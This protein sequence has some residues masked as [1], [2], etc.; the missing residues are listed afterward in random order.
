[1][2]G[3]QAYCQLKAATT[4]TIPYG[5]RTT[6]RAEPRPTIV[7]CM[8]RASAMPRT[9][10]MAT[11]TTVMSRVMPNAVHQYADVSTAT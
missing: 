1:M 2:P 8:T 7:R 4:V 11:E 5:I 9:S 6:V 10:S 3:V